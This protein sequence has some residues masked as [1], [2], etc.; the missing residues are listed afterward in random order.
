MNSEQFGEV[1]AQW[2]QTASELAAA[3]MHFRQTKH[4]LTLAKANAW[5]DGQVT[6]GNA[7]ARKAALY[8]IVEPFTVK[9]IEAEEAVMELE[10]KSRYLTST[11][12]YAIWH[13]F[14]S[15][16]PFT[17]I[18]EFIDGTHNTRN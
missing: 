2:F 6:G 1:N 3:H 17:G 10:I 18:R 16:Q 12:E 11:I 5:A 13:G 8:L 9:L 15:P 7:D 4:E 14:Q